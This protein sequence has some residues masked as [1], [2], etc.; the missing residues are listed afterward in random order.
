MTVG[1][2]INGT[3]YEFE[4][5][6]KNG[7]GTSLSAAASA[8][9]TN[10]AVPGVLLYFDTFSLNGAV[11]LWWDPPEYDGG[12]PITDY[13]YQYRESG[14][15]WNGWTSA[16]NANEELPEYTVTGLTN[17][18]AY[19]FQVRA[20]N[21]V[22]PG[23]ETEILSETPNA[24]KPD[25]PTG[26]S[27]TAGT[28]AGTIELTW[29]APNANGSAI[30]G[31]KFTYCKYNNGWHGW[32]QLSPT[33]STSTSFTVTGLE[34]GETYRFRVAATNSVGDSRTSVAAQTNAP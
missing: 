34:T 13:E 22:G 8:T 17:G 14:G 19:E 11:D 1:S 24:K 32:T 26:L 29:T 9:P 23:P 3:T 16:G 6:A 30:T 28:T 20:R 10:T 12:S 25:A 15:N 2:L 7:A 33:G 4:V 27:A 18:T 31:Y 5:R 21:A